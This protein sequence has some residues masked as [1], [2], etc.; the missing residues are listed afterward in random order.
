MG[1][2]PAWRESEADPKRGVKGDP[3]C[4]VGT[5]LVSGGCSAAFPLPRDPRWP[6]TPLLGLRGYVSSLGVGPPKTGQ[7]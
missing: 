6:R 4:S 2:R 1:G 7:G 5:R 3:G